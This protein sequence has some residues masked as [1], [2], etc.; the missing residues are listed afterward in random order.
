MPLVL[1]VA[2]P[3]IASVLA[4]LLPQNARNR[5]STLAGLVA[6]GCAVQAAW[7]FP[8]LAA[9]QR[10]PLRDRLAA[11]ARARPGPAHGRLRLDVLRCWSLGIGA[12]VVLYARYYMSPDGSGAALLLV[13]PRL[14]GRDAGRRAVGQP[15]PAGAVLGAHQPLLVPADRLLAPP[16]RRA[17]RRAH[18]ADRDRRG[19]AVP[20]GRRAAARAASSAATT[21]TWCSRRATRS[22]RMRST[23]PRW[24]WCCWARFTKSAQFPFHFWLPHAMAAPTPVSA[25]LHSATMVKAGRVPAGAAV[26]GAVGHRAVVLAGRR[27][28]R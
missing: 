12:L 19:R 14:H 5:E 7:L 20:A 4:A 17:A 8:Q 3:F 11:R 6:L 2:L 25:Y 28:R 24:C 27:R 21:S 15:G 1:L 9:R 22:A 13:L 26:A 23:R 16:A 18:G 10:D